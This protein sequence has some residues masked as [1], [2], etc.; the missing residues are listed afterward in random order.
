MD[1]QYENG[2]F[3]PHPILRH[4]KSGNDLTILARRLGLV[5]GESD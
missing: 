5:T 2:L 3:L 1:D 4:L